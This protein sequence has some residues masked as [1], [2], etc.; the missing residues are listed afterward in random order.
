M[1][2]PVRK[3]LSYRLPVTPSNEAATVNSMAEV[4]AGVEWDTGP[5]IVAWVSETYG[6]VQVWAADETEGRYVARIAIGHM[7]ASED[8]DGE[9]IVTQSSSPRMGRRVRVRATVVSARAQPSGV[10]PHRYLP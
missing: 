1:T 7:G 2:T 3:R 9:W 5:V 10:A 4:W 6:T 8:D